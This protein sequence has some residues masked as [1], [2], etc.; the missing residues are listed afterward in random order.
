MTQVA[1]SAL[2]ELGLQSLKENAVCKCG[3]DTVW[4]YPHKFVKTFHKASQLEVGLPLSSSRGEVLC[5]GQCK[6]GL[7]S[8]EINWAN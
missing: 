1:L 5:H 7:S 4:C 6:Q 2:S 3:F 8:A